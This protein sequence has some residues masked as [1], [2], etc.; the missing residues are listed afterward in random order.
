[1]TTSKSRPPA[2]LGPEGRTLW[3]EIVQETADDGLIL[4]ARERR[5]LLDAAR[6][7]DLCTAMMTQLDGADFMVKGSQGQPVAHPILGEL[8]MH[9]AVIGGLLARIKLTDPSDSTGTGT[10]S[11]TTST[12]ARAAALARHRGI[13]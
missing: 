13:G 12:Q 5:W 2:G 6:E 4:D 11:R 8:R 9:R 10:G 3:R 7:A 1:M